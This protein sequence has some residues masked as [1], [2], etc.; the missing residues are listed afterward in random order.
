MSGWPYNYL[1]WIG[2]AIIFYAY[3]GYGLLLWLL[4]HLKR[5]FIGRPSLPNSSTE[6][7]VTFIVCAYN[8]EK[9]IAQKIENSLQLEYPTDSIRFV[10]MTDGSDDQTTQIAEKTFE[11]DSKPTS[12]FVLHEPARKGKIAAFHRAMTHFGKWDNHPAS[13]HII[14]STDA[15]T[16][17][18][19]LAV[20]QLIKHFQNPKVGAVAGEKRIKMDH[21][22]AA[23]AAGEGIYWRYEST[24]KKWDA[25][26]WSVVGAAGE[27]FAFRS[28]LYE[29]VPEDTIVEDFYLTTKIAKFRIAEVFVKTLVHDMLRLICSLLFASTTLAFWQSPAPRQQQR[30]QHAVIGQFSQIGQHSADLLRPI[31]LTS[32]VVLEQADIDFKDGSNLKLSS[33]FEFRGGFDSFRILG[34]LIA[35]ARKTIQLPMFDEA[36]GLEVYG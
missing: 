4:L 21:V 20:Q 35:K 7:K 17:L 36:S 34:K 9:W 31:P 26:L 18:N 27:L 33:A 10:V 22:D 23:S 29:P 13:A 5:W 19:R 6:C 15:N 11:I 32:T 3:I 14:V 16:L 25:E 8:E 12:H 30:N 24:L 1:F 28:D 2:F